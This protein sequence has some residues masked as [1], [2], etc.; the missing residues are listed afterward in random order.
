MHTQQLLLCYSIVHISSILEYLVAVRAKVGEMVRNLCT[1]KTT[2]CLRGR[3]RIG[4]VPLYTH[5][6]WVFVWHHIRALY[7]KQSSYKVCAAQTQGVP[8]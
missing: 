1:C 7:Y 3:V 5:V 2:F 8:T 6:W 4:D